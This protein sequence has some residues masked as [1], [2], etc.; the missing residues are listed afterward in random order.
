MNVPDTRKLERPEEENA[1]LKGLVAH[2]TF[3]PAMPQ[4]VLGR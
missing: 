3:D 2:L 1:L 4:D